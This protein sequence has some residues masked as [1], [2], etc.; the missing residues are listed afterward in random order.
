M[1]P[2]APFSGTTTWAVMACDLFLTLR[3]MFS[4]ES[5]HA[6]VEH[7]RVATDQRWATRDLGIEPL[8]FAVVDRQHV[9]PDRLDQPQALQ[10][11]QL[12]GHLL[13]E[14]VSLR[15]VVGGVQLPDVLVERGELP[16]QDP[17]GG[18]FRAGHP[19]LM[20]DATVAKHLEVLRLAELGYARVAEGREPCSC[21]A[22]ASAE[23]R[24]RMP[25]RES[26]PRRAPSSPRRSDG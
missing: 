6:G 9:V 7:L 2:L 19:A 20:I 17:R 18:V 24:S 12:L 25:A 23:C 1:T 11:A 16:G 10:L 14:V 5:A 21:R 15:P 26:R 13:R 3:T 22:A 4:G 8:R